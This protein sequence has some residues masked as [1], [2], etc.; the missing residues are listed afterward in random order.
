[1]GR[2]F[3]LLA[4]FALDVWLLA[5]FAPKLAGVTLDGRMWERAV[6]SLLYRPGFTRRQGPG[7][8]SLFG[9]STASGVSHEIDGA[10]DNWRGSIIVECKAVA[11]GISKSDAAVFHFKVMDYYQNKIT[12]TAVEKWW[13]ILCGATSSATSARATAISLGLIL[14]DQDRLPLPVLLRAAGHPEAD[15]YLPDSLLQEIVRLG[16]RALRPLQEKWRYDQNS[17]EIAF[18]PYQWSGSEIN[19]LLWLEDE[20]SNSIIERYEKCRPDVLERRASSLIW[21]I[22]KAA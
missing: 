14:C 3:N 22:Q 2:P 8:L 5:K 12:T 18:R 15:L 11:G 21:F 7:N 9:K 16:E 10:A 19:D 13:P 20:M 4:D 17:G 1:M 6:T